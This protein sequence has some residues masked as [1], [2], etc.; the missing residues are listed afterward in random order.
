MIAT[1]NVSKL[2]FVNLAKSGNAVGHLSL[3]DREG[4]AMLHQPMHGGTR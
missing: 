3:Y 4:M 2:Q 1:G